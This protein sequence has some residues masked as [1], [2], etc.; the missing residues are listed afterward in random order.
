MFDQCVAPLVDGLF[1]GYNATVLAYGQVGIDLLIRQFVFVLDDH[2]ARPRSSLNHLARIP[3]AIDAAKRAEKLGPPRWGLAHGKSQ[4]DSMW[5]G[6]RMEQPIPCS[7]FLFFLTSCLCHDGVECLLPEPP[8]AHHFSFG[9]VW[10][11]GIWILINPSDHDALISFFPLSF[12]PNRL[13]QGR[14]TLWGLPAR[15]DHILGS[16]Q[17]PWLHCLTRLRA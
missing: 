3:C 1:Q 11:Q 6:A 15:R 4:H 8:N 9:L 17:G 2:L 12:C 14:P 16:S 5:S 10:I 7:F 13:G